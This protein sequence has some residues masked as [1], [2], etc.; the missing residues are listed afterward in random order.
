MCSDWSVPSS[1]DPF[2][3]EGAWWLVTAKLLGIIPL[4]VRTGGS[5]HYVDMQGRGLASS[6]SP[7]ESSELLK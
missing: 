6:L 5:E 2:V 7:Q 3:A 1:M 4:I